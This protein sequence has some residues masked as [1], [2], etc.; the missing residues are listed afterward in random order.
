MKKQHIT[1]FYVETLLL[2]VVFI[3]ILLVLTQIFGLSKLR[4]G[5][6]ERLTNAVTL[7]GNA[8]EVFAEA[9]SP[10]ELAA[11]LNE[12]GNA[13]LMSDTA[14]VTARYGRDMAPDPEG[15]LTVEIY[16]LEEPDGFV[17]ARIRVLSEGVKE[18]VYTLQ[19]ASYRQEVAG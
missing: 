4:S 18:P 2:I 10:E 3:A 1:G 11:L 15:S 16:W 19:T 7:A 6:A 14:G 5:E 8:A 9:E 12:N 13:A 17:E